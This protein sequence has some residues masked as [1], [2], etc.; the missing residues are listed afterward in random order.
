[1]SGLSVTVRVEPDLDD[2]DDAIRRH[3]V[4]DIR[5]RVDPD[6]NSNR[7]NRA[8]SGIS[9]LLGGIGRAATGAL[10]VGA[11]GGAFATAASGAVA[12][13]NAMGPA[14]GILAAAPAAI[15]TSVTAFAA[16]KLALDGVGDA[17]GAALTGDAEE[18]AEAI[19]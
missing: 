7:I 8:L 9:G 13:V 1:L 11:L 14:V 16:L 6:V 2:L 12:L 3:R 17:F 18:F 4:P 10:R 5:V 15:L 19:E